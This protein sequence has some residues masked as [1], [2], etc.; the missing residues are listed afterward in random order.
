MYFQ[1]MRN[2]GISLFITIVVVGVI[3]YI[4]FAVSNI[5]FQQ[6]RLSATSENSQYAFYSANSAIECALYWDIKKGVFPIPDADGDGTANDGS[7]DD[8]TT[9]DI[10]CNKKSGSELAPEGESDIVAE[11]DVTCD[12]NGG[13][14]DENG[15]DAEMCDR[16]TFAIHGFSHADISSCVYE[17]IVQKEKEGGNIFTS[18]EAK[19]RAPVDTD[20]TLTDK[21]VERAIRI[22]Y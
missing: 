19:G 16:T 17:V 4:A 22:Q 9:G 2:R 20:C 7:V 12:A 5:G 18:I 10:M 14:V 8:D 13:D 15:N 11:E 21:T 6:L 1:N 3:S